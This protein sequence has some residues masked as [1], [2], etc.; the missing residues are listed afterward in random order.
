M[1]DQPITFTIAK[2]TPDFN[3][4]WRMFDAYIREARLSCEGGEEIEKEYFFSMEY[5]V[6]IEQLINRRVDPMRILF[7]HKSGERI[8][9]LTYLVD[10]AQGG[11]CTLMHYALIPEM[12]RA[13][14]GHR[15]YALAE[16]QMRQDGATAVRLTPTNDNNTRF[17][18]SVGYVRTD[19][20]DE[21]GAPLFRKAL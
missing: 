14:R 6:A 8:G 20:L 10:K 3:A 18:L 13:G 17:W 16:A 21:N 15:I 1:L 11:L 9:F 19:D 5:R 4:F 2:D 7:F 12:R